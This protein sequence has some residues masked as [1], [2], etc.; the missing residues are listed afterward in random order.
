MKLKTL[1]RNLSEA[2]EK[3][4]AGS[5]F[6]AKWGL[7]PKDSAK[8]ASFLPPKP[9]DPNKKK[10]KTNKEGMRISAG[11]VVLPSLHPDD[12]NFCYVIKPSNN[13]GPWAFPKG[14]IDGNETF[15]EAA[16]REVREET[17]ITCTILPGGY[18]GRGKG[19]TTVTHYFM[20][21]QTGGAVKHDHEVEE[22]R[23]ASFEEAWKLFAGAGNSRDIDILKKAWS[24]T[25][26]LRNRSKIRTVNDTPK[27]AIPEHP[28][29]TKISDKLK[30]VKPGVK[31]GY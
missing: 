7:A 24:F 26:K 14:N 8:S 20:A 29:G 1:I 21:V 15:P 18:L 13:F 28:D 23:L 10:R 12:L 30:S 11:C 22:V 25:D 19:R 9:E 3:Y 2:S 31:S 4:D 5:D 6:W 16:R 27:A 17:G